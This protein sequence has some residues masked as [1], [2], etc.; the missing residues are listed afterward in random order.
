MYL[1][2]NLTDAQTKYFIEQV[3]EWKHSYPSWKSADV[4]ISVVQKQSFLSPPITQ[5]GSVR[6]Q[7]RPE[8]RA[9]DP[10]TTGCRDS[11]VWCETGAMEIITNKMVWTVDTIS[12]T[13]GWPR[14]WMSNW[15]QIFPGQPVVA[16]RFSFARDHLRRRNTI[17]LNVVKQSDQLNLTFSSFKITNLNPTQITPLEAWDG[18]HLKNH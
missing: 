15:L 2:I 16:K 12:L 5:R 4:Y 17:S 18:I 1:H 14:W 11:G 3:L 9:V 10:I 7:L 6:C 8:P 13:C